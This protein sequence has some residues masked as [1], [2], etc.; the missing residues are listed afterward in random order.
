MEM[1]AVALA[2]WADRALFIVKA[3]NTPQRKFHP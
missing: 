1:K 3:I 2:E